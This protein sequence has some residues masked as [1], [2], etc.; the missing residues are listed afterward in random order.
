MRTRHGPCKKFCPNAYR[1]ESYGLLSLLCFLRRLAEFTG[2]HDQWY[3]V[4]ATDSQSLIDTVLQRNIKQEHSGVDST[5]IGGAQRQIKTHPLDPTLPDWDVIRGIQVLLQQM[6]ELKLK[7]VKGHQDRDIP[8]R[9]LSLLAQLNV[10]ADAQ[11]SQYQRDLGSPGQTCSLPNGQGFTWSFHRAQSQ[12]IMKQRYD[13]RQLRPRYRL[14][15]RSDTPGHHKPWQRLT[16]KLM[17]QRLTPSEETHISGKTGSRYSSDESSP[18]SIRSTTQSLPKLS[19][20]SRKLAA[21]PVLSIR[22]SHVVAKFVPQDNGSD[23]HQARDDATFAGTPASSNSR[24]VL[25][26]TQ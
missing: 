14:I 15:C 19:K 22:R 23:M 5:F 7:H 8:Y 6:P 10:D 13:I 16:G 11:A 17:A 1:S 20:R 2:K 4:V 25:A 24:V 9:H 3:G 18:P 12:P 21:Y 26:S